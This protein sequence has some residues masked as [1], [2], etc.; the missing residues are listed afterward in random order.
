MCYG[1]RAHPARIA[2]GVIRE[3]TCLAKSELE[4]GA[5]IDGAAIEHTCRIRCDRMCSGVIIHPCDG[6]ARLDLQLSGLEAATG[7]GY[8]AADRSSH[9]RRRSLGRR[10][11]MRGF[12]MLGRGGIR[13]RFLA[14]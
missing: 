1:D 5:R 10:R 3:C 11:S 14:A 2:G 8:G 6:R 13:G 12:D 7:N 4:C 9:G